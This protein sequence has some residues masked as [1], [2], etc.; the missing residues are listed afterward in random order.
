MKTGANKSDVVKITK[1]AEGG[2]DVDYISRA[3]QIEADVVKT[4]MPKPKESKSKSKLSSGKPEAV[5][6][7]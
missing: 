4:F 6:S 7:D 3:L 2:D 5:A 1:M